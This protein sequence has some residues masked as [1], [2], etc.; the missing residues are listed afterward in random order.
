MF[1]F[2]R[3]KLR[4]RHKQRTLPF[5]PT[6][7]NQHFCRPISLCTYFLMSLICQHNA[8]WQSH[9]QLWS[10]VWPS[11]HCKGW[12]S[13]VL[14]ILTGADMAT[15][16]T[17]WGRGDGQNGTWVDGEKGQGIGHGGVWITPRFTGSSNHQILTLFLCLMYLQESMQTCV[18]YRAGTDSNQPMALQGLILWQGNNMPNSTIRYTIH[19][20]CCIGAQGVG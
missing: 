10:W 4:K 14:G 7:S 6:N 13:D 19:W 16:G 3:C 20:R 12:V 17:K 11:R 18:G 5:F 1:I 8:I 9:M 15:Q 2:F